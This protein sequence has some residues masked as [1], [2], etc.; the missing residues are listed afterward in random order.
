[1]PFPLV[2]AGLAGLLEATLTGI[3]VSA[4]IGIIVSRV[5]E[6]FASVEGMV[7]LTDTVNSALSEAGLSLQFTNV[8]SISDVKSDLDDFVVEMVNSKLGTEFD[9]L[10]MTRDE[11][12]TV[13]GETLAGRINAETGASIR[14]VYPPAE[15]AEE[16]K[17]DLVRQLE[18]GGDG[19]IP[20]SAIMEVHR[21]V[22][23]KLPGYKPERIPEDAG[24]AA[25]SRARQK[26][27]RAKNKQIWV[28]R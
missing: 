6:W 24:K 27:W 18:S 3:A 19:L 9:T 20:Q 23:E 12:L 25:K 28:T 14:T 1:M 2:L 4:S 7:F 8:F 5:K 15:F 13:I 17:K 21:I 11:A 22:M 26:R 16:I 10:D